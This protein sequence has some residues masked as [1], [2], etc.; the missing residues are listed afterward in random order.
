M[1]EEAG[2]TDSTLE[3]VHAISCTTGEKGE[4]AVC[5]GFGDTPVVEDITFHVFLSPSA[6]PDTDA[7]SKEPSRSCHSPGTNN[8][9]LYIF[10]S[11]CLDPA[12]LRTMITPHC[13]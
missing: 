9:T 6:E 11:A 2:V 12:I 8:P 1:R 5:A 4:P 10:L 3:A 13:T 7:I